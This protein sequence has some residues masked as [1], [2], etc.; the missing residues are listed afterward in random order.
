MVLFVLVIRKVGVNELLNTIKG[1]DTVWIF[2]SLLIAPILVFV[3]VIKWHILLKSQG[4]KVSVIRLY[5]YY[6]V[7]R[8]FNY[9]L[10][11]N[12]GGDVV[13]GYELG[14]YTQNNA[15]AMASVFMERF[16]GFVMLVGFA[17]VSLLTN[18]KLINDAGLTPVVFLSVVVLL[19]ILWLVLDTR[20]LLFLNQHVKV[21]IAQKFVQ[22]LQKFHNSINAY[23]KKKL[24]LAIALFWSLIFM[25][26]AI[27][28]VYASASAFYQPISWVDISIIVP[29]ILVVA[30]FPITINGF[31]IQEWA[32]VFL[33]T[34]IGLPASVGL[35]TILLIRGKDILLAII[36]GLVYPVLRIRDER[37]MN[38]NGIFPPRLSEKEQNFVEDT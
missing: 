18:F 34:M 38:D 6:L 7:G 13:R 33:F 24:T 15:Q 10:P 29:V 21:P 2:I 19:V 30:M 14:N 25:L 12:V 28:N 17:V 1:A 4:T 16:T 3:S 31:G 32:Y 11:S 9:F 5:L 27:A 26:L 37:K 36:G 8:Y 22:K 35:S 23:R 20:P